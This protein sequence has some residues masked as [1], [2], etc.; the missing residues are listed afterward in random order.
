M[1]TL[2]KAFPSSIV[3]SAFCWGSYWMA[4]FHPHVVLKLLCLENQVLSKPLDGSVLHKEECWTTQQEQ[5]LM[6]LMGH[7]PGDDTNSVHC[8]DDWILWCH[9]WG[10]GLAEWINYLRWTNSDQT[11]HLLLGGQKEGSLWEEEQL[12]SFGE[13]IIITL[14]LALTWHLISVSATCWGS[15]VW[16]MLLWRNT[17]SGLLET[18]SHHYKIWFQWELHFNF[19]HSLSPSNRK[20]YQVG[21]YFSPNWPQIFFKVI[22]FQHNFL[23]A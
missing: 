1:A 11:Q 18:H 16:H 5:Q 15:S 17:R 19:S 14:T 20:C 13:V 8:E 12:A 22:Y 3:E 23:K 9:S 2:T 10:W 6:D 4:T 21:V 7:S